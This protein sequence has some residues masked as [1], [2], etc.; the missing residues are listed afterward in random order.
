RDPQ[1][2]RMA[3]KVGSPTGLCADAEP[4]VAKRQLV[5]EE[6]ER[7]RAFLARGDAIKKGCP[8]STDSLE[9]EQR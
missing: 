9:R 1:K 3:Q 4:R 8:R 5:P 2:K 6:T 7:S